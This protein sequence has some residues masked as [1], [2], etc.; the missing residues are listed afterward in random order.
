VTRVVFMGSDAIALPALD[1][2][3]GEGAGLLELAGVVTNPDRPAGRGRRLHANPVKEWARSRRL[4]I[5][6]PERL[7]EAERKSLAELGP[8]LLLVMAYGHLLPEAILNLPRLGTLNVHASL[9]PR[10]RG[11]SP[12]QAAI[13]AGDRETG[14]TLMRIVRELDAGPIAGAERIPLLP[15][16]TTSEVETRLGAATP[17][18]LSRTLPRLAAGELGFAEQK[19][20]EATYCRKLEKGDGLLDFAA[21]AAELAG[22]VNALHPWPGAVVEVGTVAVKVGLAAALPAAGGAA[23]P[24]TVLEPDGQSLRIA[25]GEGVIALLRLQRPGGRLLAATEFLRGFPVPPGTVLPS[26]PM[27]PLISSLPF[28]KKKG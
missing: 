6:E 13:A 12:V 5:L 8:D 27:R 21:P 20:S 10:H 17:R 16:D 23:A 28:A 15:T 7:G 24:G 3:M 14:V 18:L 9:L 4:P 25:T 22:R 2:L 26:H 1:W 19:K 11:A